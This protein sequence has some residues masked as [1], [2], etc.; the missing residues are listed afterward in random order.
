MSNYGQTPFDVRVVGMALNDF[1]FEAFNTIAGLG[2][3]TFGFLWPCDGVWAPADEFVVT[4]WTGCAG[5]SMGGNTEN[6]I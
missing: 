1:G 4:V 5:A 6:C 2:L 3:N